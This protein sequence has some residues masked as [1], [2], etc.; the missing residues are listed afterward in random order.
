MLPV[1]GVDA[2]DTLWENEE[3]FHE[4]EQRFRDL[5]TPWADS[6]TADAALLATER[7]NIARHGYGIKGFVLSMVLTAVEISDAAIDA[8]SLAGIVGW[9]HE[10]LA[11]P[12]ELLD[13]VPEALDA[14]GSTHRLL[15]ITKGDLGDQLSKVRRSGLADR[16]W[17]V[18]V[19][20]EKD[21]QTYRD[22]LD[23]HGVDPAEFTMVG[24]SVKS[25]VL[26]VLAI[27]GRAI[28]VPHTTTWVFE[29]PNPDELAGVEFPIVDRLGDVSRLIAG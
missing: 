18:E 10:M 28:H 11:H 27:G 3:R 17:R 29:E 24:N 15:L 14:L 9:G 22:V 4:V 21:P 25:D 13:G 7:T 2:D 1:L 19:V 6:E 8:R 26:P 23:R 16:F 5:V 20:P 12:I